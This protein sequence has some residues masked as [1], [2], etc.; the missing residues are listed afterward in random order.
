MNIAML[1]TAYMHA[2]KALTHIAWVYHNII[3][4]FLFFTPENQITE[5]DI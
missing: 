2:L 3:F 5:I 1:D 4:F